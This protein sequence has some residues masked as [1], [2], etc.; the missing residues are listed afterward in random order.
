M[1]NPK[2]GGFSGSSREPVQGMSWGRVTWPRIHQGLSPPPKRPLHL[3]T[4]TP[5][6]PSEILQTWNSEAPAL[7]LS[8]ET[9]QPT[10]TWSQVSAPSSEKGTQGCRKK[11]VSALNGPSPASSPGHFWGTV[12]PL[13]LWEEAGLGEPEAVKFNLKGNIPQKQ[14]GFLGL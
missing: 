1:L 4:A 7:P 10:V 14:R 6:A 9:S 5:D 2:A 12:K 3:F 13:P 11:F 8:H